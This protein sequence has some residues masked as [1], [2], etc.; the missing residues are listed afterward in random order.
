MAAERLNEPQE[1][2]TAPANWLEHFGLQVLKS[3]W[4]LKTM[5]IHA[6]WPST[7]RRLSLK[8]VKRYLGGV[9]QA[10]Q[11]SSMYGSHAS[12]H[13]GVVNFWDHVLVSPPAQVVLHNMH[14]ICTVLSCMT[15]SES[16]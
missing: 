3:H 4:C 2:F 10:C 6:S 5:H 15:E 1:C 9:T 7:A 13:I 14:H 8:A 16:A 11:H 12:I